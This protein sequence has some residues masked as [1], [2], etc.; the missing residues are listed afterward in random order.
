MQRITRTV[1]LAM[2]LSAIVTTGSRAQNPQAVLSWGGLCPTRVKNMDFTG[3]G[4]YVLWVGAKNLTSSDSN[5]DRVITLNFRPIVADAWRFDNAGCQGPSLMTAYSN[6]SHPDS[7]SCPTMVGTSPI[8]ITNFT[9]DP[10][11][12]TAQLA[13]AAAYNVFVPSPG[14]TYT[15]WKILFD[16]S[17]SAVGTSDP[18]AC[19]NAQLA[20]TISIAAGADSSYLHTTSNTYEAL[21]FADPSDQAVT[22]NAGCA[23][24]AVEEPAAVRRDVSLRPPY[25]NPTTGPS[26]LE[27][28]LPEPAAARV[29]VFDIAGRLVK[30]IHDGWDPA[31]QQRFEWDGREQSGRPARAGVYFIRLEV[32]G[33]RASEQLTRIP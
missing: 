31:G 26:T 4:T 25:P 33:Q 32:N 8:T 13:L 7:K 23:T 24:T 21:T 22:W 28:T 9:Y 14:V 5:T 16:H 30:L 12:M 11:S 10:G 20:M 18:T 17:N 15:L 1:V 2:A 29:E 3:P 19:G 27:Y 6:T